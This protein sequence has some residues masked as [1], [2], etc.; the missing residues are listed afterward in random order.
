MPFFRINSDLHYSCHVPQCGGVSVESYLQDRFGELAFQNSK[1]YRRP[2]G[3]RWTK[4][5][6]QH[7]DVH[8]T[9][10]TVVRLFLEPLWFEF[11]PVFHG[12]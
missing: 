3:H 2:E 5:S 9:S 1:F 8:V 4:T 10:R 7:V 11:V 12:L 6:P